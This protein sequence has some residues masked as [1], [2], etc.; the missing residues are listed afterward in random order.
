M[1]S[2]HTGGASPRR[3]RGSRVQHVASC[4]LLAR[5]WSAPP[6]LSALRR[7]PPV[8]RAAGQC[9][10]Q[11]ILSLAPGFGRTDKVIDGLSR[12][13]R[14]CASNICVPP[15]PRCTSSPDRQGQ[16]SRVPRCA[17]APAPGFPRAHRRARRPPLALRRGQ[18]RPRPV[19]NRPMRPIAD[20]APCPRSSPGRHAAHAEE[21]NG[22]RTRPAADAEPRSSVSSSSCAHRP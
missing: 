19:R 5:R 6:R 8:S 18:M 3:K 1:S 17:G 12:T 22:A 7:H 11:I 15:A 16:G 20:P 14:R 21:V 9:S 4:P 13:M 2:G 10:E